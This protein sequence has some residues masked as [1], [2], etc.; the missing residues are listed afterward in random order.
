MTEQQAGWSRRSVNEKKGRK[1]ASVGVRFRPWIVFVAALLVLSGIAVMV[2]IT[3]DKPSGALSL[4]TDG[5]GLTLADARPPRP[6]DVVVS[7]PDASSGI[8]AQSGAQP[9]TAEGESEVKHNSPDAEEAAEQFVEDFDG[10]TDLWADGA[11]AKNATLADVEKFSALFRRLPKSH[12]EECLQRALNLIP[13]ENVML[14]VGILMDKSQEKEL[15]ELVYN[16]ILNRDEN[17]KKPILQ[18]IFKDKAHP[19]W[20]DTAWILDVTDE[21]PDRK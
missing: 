12:K 16:D 9:D 11:A 15:V 4:R 14:L 10:M 13:D 18:Q 2:L 5:K 1:S 19:C 21:L 8:M 7:A 20:A 3:D 17:V 6:G